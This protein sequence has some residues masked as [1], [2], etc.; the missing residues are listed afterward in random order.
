MIPV[1]TLALVAGAQELRIDRA[2]YLKLA[3]LGMEAQLKV[4]DLLREKGDLEG[5]VKAYRE[6]TRLFAEALQR[7]EARPG[8]RDAPFTGPARAGP[9]D[10]GRP[11]PGLGSSDRARGGRRN[12]RAGGGSGATE[13]AVEHGLKWLADHQD[14]DDHGGWDCDGFAKHDPAA[15]KCDGPGG[16]LYDAGVTGLALLAYLGAGYTDRG[17]EQ[18]NKYGKNVRQGLR[19]LM[20][21]QDDQG[22]FG[23]RATHSFIYNHAI[24]TLALCE[25]YWMT[26]NPR[27]KAPAQAGLDFIAR[28]R[29]PYLA[30]RYGVRSGENDTSIT[31]WCVMALKAGQFAG[32]NVDPDAF[33]G[34]RAW[35]DK[36]TD[37]NTGQV[38][39]NFP[40]GSV[41]RPEGM[42]NAFPAEKSQAMTAS[43]ILTRIFTGENPRSELVRKSADLCLKHPPRWDPDGG[44][45]DLYY[46]YWGTL[47]MYQVGDA[48]WR[49]WNEA[50]KEAIVKQQ[51]PAGSGARTGSWDPRG[52]W[53]NDGGRVYATALMTMC[54]EVYYRYDRVVGK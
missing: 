47:A 27:Y 24:A 51:H 42:V 54:L 22:C 20:T 1:V 41:A 31:G 33:Q 18:E 35:I 25:A 4:G 34:A 53:Q 3:R 39:Y 46:W 26:R 28:A 21:R 37:P 44:T 17:T 38:G 8:R 19:Y 5:A 29:N 45:I 32:L 6:A 9:R 52:P 36:V 13:N 23:T 30:W 43:G 15:D 48:H 10:A 50:M 12:L 14:V 16:A 2:E 7:L 49:R 40:G 11:G